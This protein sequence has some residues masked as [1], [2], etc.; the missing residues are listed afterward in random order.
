MTTR[1]VSPDA[2]R[3]PTLTLLGEHCH[4]LAD[5]PDARTAEPI[6]VSQVPN[7]HPQFRL[8][9]NRALALEAAHRTRAGRQPVSPL[10]KLPRTLPE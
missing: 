3:A 10:R 5:R 6:A 7:L 4:S 9:P 1:K 8:E 2:W